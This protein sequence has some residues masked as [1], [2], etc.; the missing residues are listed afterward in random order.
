MKQLLLFLALFTGFS[1]F[2]Q[3]GTSLEEYRYLSKGYVYQLEMGLDAQ[4]EGYLVKDLYEASNGADLVGLYQIGNAE[5]RALLVILDNGKDKATYVCLPN[6]DAN[7]RV[8]DLAIAD[9]R[10]FSNDQK[11]DYQAALNEF[12]FAAL[13]NPD[14]KVL[15]YQPVKSAPVNYQADETLVSRSANLEQYIPKTQKEK[16][17]E[18]EVVMTNTKASE[19]SLFGEIAN[20]TILQSEEAYA[21]TE[22]RGTIAIKIC[23]DR[24]GNVM[25]AKFTQ[26][27][28]TT[29]NS[30]L[31]KVALKAAK[32]IKFATLD[33]PEQCGIVNYKF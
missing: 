13:S 4:K 11:A 23:V 27:G 29:F 18:P 5:P 8:K 14:I 22:K 30:Y 21:T 2:A 1:I 33:V 32:S 28:S 25:S 6:G 26:R 7:Q 31:K 10:D 17:I 15:S 16:T 20:R 12:L 19:R 3:E 24:A 9:Q